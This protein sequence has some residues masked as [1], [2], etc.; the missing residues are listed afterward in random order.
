MWVCQPFGMLEK[1]TGVAGLCCHIGS[2][3]GVFCP[4]YLPENHNVGLTGSSVSM[5]V[6]HFTKLYVLAS[7]TAGHPLGNCQQLSL[8]VYLPVYRAPTPPVR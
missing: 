6:T 4:C 3:L 2:S 8:F 1:N 5:C 7:S